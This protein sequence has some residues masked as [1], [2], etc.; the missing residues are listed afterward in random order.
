MSRFLV[1][2][3]MRRRDE[4][5]EQP[6]SSLRPRVNRDWSGMRNSLTY[7]DYIDMAVAPMDYDDYGS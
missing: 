6:S 5:R 7:Y 4:P 3:D 1:E 2:G